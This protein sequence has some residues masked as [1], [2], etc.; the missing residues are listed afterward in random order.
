MAQLCLGAPEHGS[1]EERAKLGE[2]GTGGDTRG[3]F[4]NLE[5]CHRAG[6]LGKPLEKALNQPS[7]RANPLHSTL[8]SSPPGE[9]APG[10]PRGTAQA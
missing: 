9:G 6:C 2:G 4:S 10:P 7:W 3:E 8:G 1:G 5:A